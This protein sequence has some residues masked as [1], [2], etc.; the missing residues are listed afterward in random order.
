MH[1]ARETP[2]ATLKRR[3]DSLIEEADR[4]SDETAK[5]TVQADQFDLENQM[6]S[7]PAETV[8]DVR[9]QL[10]ALARM[11]EGDAVERFAKSALRVLS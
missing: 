8:A 3:V 4:I 7:M 11:Y 2:V 5:N 6:I 10:E 1:T 9:A